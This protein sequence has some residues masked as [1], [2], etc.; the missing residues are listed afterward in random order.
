ME[1]C[2]SCGKNP[3]NE[4]NTCPYG[5]EINNDNESLCNCCNECRQE[6]GWNI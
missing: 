3:A 5:E 2:D 6:C 4:P 1:M